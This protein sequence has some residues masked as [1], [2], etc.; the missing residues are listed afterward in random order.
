MAVEYHELP[1]ARK[2]ALDL[3]LAIPTTVALLAAI[4]HQRQYSVVSVLQDSVG[5]SPNCEYIVVDVES[6]GVPKKNPVGIEFR[7]RLALRVPSDTQRLVEVFALRKDFPILIHQNQSAIGGP[8]SLCLY[9]QP[10]RAVLR[11]WTAQNFLRRIQWW[12]E[13]SAKDELHPA[14]QPAEQLFFSSLYELVLPWNFDELKRDKGQKF[15]I[16][17]GP[18]RQDHGLTLFVD[19]IAPNKSEQIHTVAHV[20]LTLPAIQHG[21]IERDP[22]TLGALADVLAARGENLLQHLFPEL[23][24][25]VG[26]KG[27]P[28]GAPEDALTVIL[29]HIPVRRSEQA[30]PDR[31]EHR[32]FIVLGGSRKLGVSVGALDL[33][34]KTYFR[35]LPKIGGEADP[36]TEWR[37]VQ[38]LPMEVL[39]HNDVSKA[40]RQSGIAEAG[41]QAVLIGA[42]SLGSA[43]LSMWGRSGWGEWTVVDQ[44]HIKPHNLARHVAYAQH[45]G[46]MKVD[47]VAALHDEV[48]CGASRVKPMR[49]DACESANTELTQVLTAAELVV[50]ASTTLDY[51][52]GASLLD[53]VGRHCSVFVSPNGCASVLM[54]EDE[55]RSLRLRTL[56]SQYYRALIGEP[57]GREHL[58]GNLG[59]FWSGASC[60][61]ISMVMP[62]SRVL[63]HAAT[64]SDQVRLAA[65][66]LG[67][68]IR[69]WQQ[70]PE[71]GAVTVHDVQ[72]HDERRLT[73]D[74]HS[75]FY[76]SGL[77]TKLL[78][79]RRASLPNET[80]GVLLGYY[81]FN[82]NA[83]ML[84]DCLPAPPDSR[85]SPC[86]F[87]RGI[88]GLAES[89]KEVSRRTAGIV[90]YVGEWHSHPAGHS[91]SPS[92]DDVMQLV[93]LALG[94]SEDGLPAVQLI[95]GER[96]FQV[97][98]G[99]VL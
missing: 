6:H 59:K 79:L 84:V 87:E 64:L 1:G 7:E 30:L 98:Q 78:D 35:C 92:R 2:V 89:V 37:D 67:A 40:R 20:E 29:L 69:V 48:M 61:D 45:V 52:R 66:R 85:S 62:Y 99:A 94:M 56:E 43:M 55:D 9:F 13:K 31:I 47:V 51:P 34:E 8:A 44:D 88:T 19:T 38:I 82:V 10:T 86:A 50:D 36:K 46:A 25:G 71:T 90:G 41:P 33:H 57:W 93:E 95:V 39:Q 24:R 26:D 5:T 42:G 96:D 97:L 27:V 68:T 91:A 12:L 32:A 16:R 11:T 4:R 81:D 74:Q 18:N 70:D 63:G 15:A 77:A 28:A 3:T 65:S 58:Q 75:L 49:A 23:Q 54:M 21:V 60:R 83:V 72:T 80:G 76:D 73:F 17:H 53:D 14:D 22:I